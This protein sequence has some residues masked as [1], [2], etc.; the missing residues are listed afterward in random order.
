M[1]DA[2]NPSPIIWSPS[3]WWEGLDGDWSSFDLRVGTP[4]QT[5]RVLPSTA[6]SATWIVTP[7]GCDPSTPECSQARGGLFNQS[8]SSTW[9]DL[10]AWTLALE[11]NLGRNESGAFGLDTISLGLTNTTGGPTLDSQIIAGIETERW[12]NGILGLQQQPMNLSSFDETHPTF[13]SSLRAKN[14]IPSLSWAYTAGARYRSKGS[15][16]SLTFGG[17]DLSRY[18][19]T[20]VSFNLAA[21]VQRDLVVGIQSITSTFN[22]GSFSSLLP[23]P[24]LA[25]I[26]STVP[27]LYL[28]DDACDAFETEL[29]L[30]YDEENNLYFVEDAL[31]QTLSNISPKFTFVLGNDKLSEPTVTIELPYA[32]FDLVIKPPLRENNTSYFPLRRGNDSQITLGRAFLQEAYVMV[33]YDRK[34][35]TITQALFDDTA[36]PNIVPI[37]WN[38]TATPIQKSKGLSRKAT[39]GISTGSSV[40]LLLAIALGVLAFLRWRKRRARQA[41]I[42]I[43]GELKSPQEAKPF[44]YISTQ[45]LGHQSMPEMHDT[46]YLEILDENYPSGSGIVINELADGTRPDTPQYEL[47]VPPTSQINELAPTPQSHELASSGS[48]P[49]QATSLPDENESPRSYIT[50]HSSAE[51]VLS[52]ATRSPESLQDTFSTHTR[53]TQG[54]QDIVSTQTKSSKRSQYN[55]S[56]H[57][58]TRPIAGESVQTRRTMNIHKALPQKPLGIT[59]YDE[60]YLSPRSRFNIE[61]PPSAR[62]ARRPS[63]VHRH[64]SQVG[65]PLSRSPYST[66]FDIAEYQNEGSVPKILHG[67]F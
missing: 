64:I 40:F 55:K 66:I 34:N 39:I 43:T 17:S 28:P 59:F 45:E 60:N 6:G 46:G 7:G 30:V 15:F 29:G 16:G 51:S 61:V 63:L 49:S 32:S 26:D 37:P 4:E 42:D 31:H 50:P 2:K 20:D 57:S 22:N 41:V 48:S 10:G 38:A 24:T 54:L 3:Q 21:D 65:R 12:Y 53:S 62:K 8:Q 33:D 18:K 67:S 58:A 19:P 11:Q 56:T 5:V 35:F 14:L 23:S 27:Y 25:F 52:K 1:P 9:E 47:Y 44:S 36:A 13:L